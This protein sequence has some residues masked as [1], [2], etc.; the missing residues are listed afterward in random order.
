MDLNA[1]EEGDWVLSPTGSV[2][3]RVEHISSKID[4]LGVLLTSGQTGRKRFEAYSN[5][6]LFQKGSGRHPRNRL[7]AADFIREVG[8]DPALIWEDGISETGYYQM[9]VGEDGQRRVTEHG[10]E[11]FWQEWPTPAIGIEVM[12]IYRGGLS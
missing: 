6:V 8:L 5:L 11:C 2:H 9:S 7:A 1:I 3:W 4:P 12:S 10:P